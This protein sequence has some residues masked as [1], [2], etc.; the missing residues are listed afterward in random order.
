LPVEPEPAATDPWDTVQRCFGKLTM[1]I[2]NVRV[3]A[4]ADA[5]YF[6]HGATHVRV[7]FHRGNEFVTPTFFVDRSAW[8]THQIQFPPDFTGA[9][10]DTARAKILVQYLYNQIF[11]ESPEAADAN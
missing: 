3:T 9:Y 8:S 10:S 4:Q 5:I 6:D 2:N 7:R 11:N 1:T